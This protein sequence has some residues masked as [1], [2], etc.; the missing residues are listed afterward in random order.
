M[1]ILALWQA[2]PCLGPKVA[3]SSNYANIFPYRALLHIHLLK[4]NNLC[5]GRLIACMQDES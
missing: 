4:I 1:K 2:I 3:N 5:F